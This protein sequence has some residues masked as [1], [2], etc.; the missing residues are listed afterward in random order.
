MAAGDQKFFEIL[1]IRIFGGSCSNA[2]SARF[3]D[4]PFV[5]ARDFSFA[6]SVPIAEMRQSALHTKHPL[7]KQL[8]CLRER[9]RCVRFSKGTAI[10][11][12]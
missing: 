5:V 8:F 10:L 9:R 12:K 3:P 1:H 2:T 7:C 11:T 6:T 4:N